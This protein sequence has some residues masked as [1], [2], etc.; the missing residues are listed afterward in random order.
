MRRAQ[1]R[2]ANR[3]ALLDAASALIAR[4][5]TAVR[6]E[7][8]A[9]AAGLTTGA[10]YSIFGSKTDLMVAVLAGEISRVD[11]AIGDG[12]DPALPLDAVIDR[13]VQTWIATY[14]GYS[15]AQTAFELHLLLSALE[16]EELRRRLAEMLDAEIGQLAR[17]LQNRVIDPARPSDRTTPAQGMV[18]ATA[19]KAI[20][21]GFGLR[22]PFMA[23]VSDLARQSC[24][25][26]TTLAKTPPGA[27]AGH[28]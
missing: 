17:L 10:I 8:I 25:T 24:Q 18:I 20:L 9:E 26:L 16:N 3:R 22:A 19:M 14:S 23:D 1:A 21:T 12:Y 11:L 7:D 6:L 15:R 13:Y 27:P 28:P 2:E 4:Q 5:G